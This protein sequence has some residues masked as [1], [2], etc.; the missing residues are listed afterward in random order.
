MNIK[1]SKIKI[2]PRIKLNC[3]IY[4]YNLCM[5]LYRKLTKILNGNDHAQK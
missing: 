1:Q 2:E 5:G 4:M 3:N